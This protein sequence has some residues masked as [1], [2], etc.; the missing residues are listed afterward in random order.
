M[1]KI[2]IKRRSILIIFISILLIM[3]TGIVGA[4]SNEEIFEDLKLPSDVE[5]LVKNFS[6][7]KYGIVMHKGDQKIQDSTIEYEY[8]GKEVVKDV[9]TEKISFKMES[10]MENDMP[11]DML[12]WLDGNDIKK[13][14]TDGEEVSAEMA[15][16]MG[17]RLLKMIFSPFYS[18]S[19]FDM[20]E[21]RTMGDVSQSQEKFGG[22]NID[23]TTVEIDNIP[24]YE[25]ESLT[26]KLG[27]FEEMSFVMSFN[28]TSTK[29]DLDINFEVDD[30]EFH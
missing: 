13:M 16:V 26:F 27:K 9:E 2:F 23:V 15:E 25:V 12:F 11:S 20:E 22:E 18:I 7:M 29:E 30:I 17:D 10:N 14:V 8:L 1:I 3:S 5:G 6:Y 28:Y 4:Q 24:E 19:E 21:L